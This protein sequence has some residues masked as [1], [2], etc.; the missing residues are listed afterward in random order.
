MLVFQ[1]FFKKVLTSGYRFILMS[2]SSASAKRWEPPSI[3]ELSEQLPQYQIEALLGRGGMGAVYKGRQ[4][5][6]D[7]PVAIKI[8]PPEIGAH[9]ATYAQRFKNEARAMAK[10]NHPGIVAVYDF[11]ETA[12][13]LLYIVMEYIEGT[14]VSRMIAKKGHLNTEHAMAISAHVCDALA[15]AHDRGIIHRDIKPANIMVGY[16]GV[17]KVGDF[18]LAKA[19]KSGDSGLTQSNVIMGTLHYMAPESLVLGVEVD[20]RAD[21]YAVGVMLYQMLTGKLPQGMFEMP[22][23][24]M[25]GLDPRYDKIVATALRDDRELRY[26]SAKDLRR[27]LDAIVTQPVLKVEADATVAPP[28]LNT[29]ARPKRPEWQPPQPMRTPT[30]RR[31]A[32]SFPYM[33]VLLVTI[34]MV[35]GWFYW[36]RLGYRVVAEPTSSRAERKGIEESKNLLAAAGNESPF[37]NTLGMKFM[38]IPETDVLFCIHETRRADYEI[39]SSAAS[40]VNSS[41]KYQHSDGVPCGHEDSHP[42]VGIIWEDAQKFCAWLSKKEGKTYRLPTDREWSIAVGI[43]HAEKW[44]PETKP[45]TVFKDQNQFPWGAEWPPPKASGNYSDASRK[46]KAPNPKASYLENYD[47]SFPTTAPTMSF[48]PNKLGLYDLEGNAREWVQEWYDSS[49]KYRVLRGGSWVADDRKGMLSSSR[50][51]VLPASVYTDVGF[52]CVLEFTTPTAVGVSTPSADRMA[53][54]ITE[55]L[56]PKSVASN[57]PVVSVTAADTELP[58]KGPTTWT[59]I[60]GR[61]L[62]ATFKTIQDESVLLEIN[63]K[64]QSVA[65]AALSSA[66]QK[67]ARDSQA[68]A[69]LPE[70]TKV[71]DGAAQKARKLAGLKSEFVRIPAGSFMMGPAVGDTAPPEQVTVSEFYIQVTE[72]TKAQWD[73][74]WI[75]A[76]SNG[77]I[78]MAEG[79]GKAPDHPVHSVSWLDAVRWC[80]ARSEKEGLKP[81]YTV[82]G[83]V[84]RTGTVEPVPDCTANGYRLPTEAEWEKAA[85]GGVS[86]KLFPSGTDTISHKQANFRNDGAEAYASGSAFYHPSYNDGV[87]PYTSPAGSFAANGYGLQ[88]MA[89]NVWEWCWERYTDPRKPTS[90]KRV[91]RGGCWGHYANSCCVTNRGHEMPAN[92]E[93]RHGFRPA[94]TTI[95]ESVRHNAKTVP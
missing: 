8:L 64:T 84:M 25:P 61:S 55:V 92:R 5:S 69:V 49:H 40:G 72:T 19:I 85:R 70:A 91:L 24:R 39:Y 18:G 23:L 28:A 46:A 93:N 26:S 78:D 89:G 29:Q 21:I 83:E 71:Q 36:Q 6:L 3:E 42:V 79:G 95:S 48:R 88:D 73:E 51:L 54:A 37:V 31:E 74:V 11:G 65:L 38:P 45:S 52:R 41:F 22:S 90:E 56:V 60:K 16:D 77:Y 4:T 20:Q 12:C 80:N 87:H 34:C 13:G 76:L 86:G 33:A 50:T 10:L 58:P 82:L 63:G 44:G 59:D 67:L 17:V 14:D 15:Y 75:W 32:R 57:A 35:A 94:R 43:G 47:D 66:S 7:R 81:V 2:H 9:D 62:V 30:M 53:G 1:L 27:D 68:L